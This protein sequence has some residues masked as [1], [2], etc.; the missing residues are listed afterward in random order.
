M[1]DL[2]YTSYD[3]FLFMNVLKSIGLKEMPPGLSSEEAEKRLKQYG[4]NEIIEEKKESAWKLLL[5]QFSSPI[6]LLLIFAAV[7]SGFTNYFQGGEY[8]DSILI[9]MIVF[10]AGIAGFVQDYK[11]EKT[12]EEL[13]KLAS[14]KAKVIRNGKIEV[15][16]S[17]EVVPGD[18]VLVEAGDVIPAD[19]VIIQGF[20][21]LDESMMT[22][23]SKAVKKK[24]KEEV[25]SG[26]NVYTGEAILK[27]TLTGMSTKMGELA[28]RMQEMK[29][30]STPFQEHMKRFTKK[31]V[32]FTLLIILI[33]FIAGFKKFGFLEALLIAVSLAVAA[34]PEGLPAVIT[35]AL[36][37]GAREMARA[38]ALVRR[39]AVTESIGSINIICT[40]K[41]GTLT[42]GKM[43]VVDEWFPGRNNENAFELFLEACY[44]CND[45]E[46]AI[47]NSEEEWVGDETDIALKKF[48]LRK[49]KEESLKGF[50]R[51]DSIPFDSKKKMMSVLV[52]SDEG[53]LVFSKG[54]P[55]VIVNKSSEIIYNGRITSLDKKKKQEVLR[56]NDELASKGYRV[57]ALA[58]KSTNKKPGKIFDKNLVFIGLVVLSDPLRKEVPQAVRE[59]HEAGIRVIMITGDNPKTALEIARQA[60][61]PSEEV[62]TGEEFEKMKDEELLKA[63]SKGVN[64][65]ART[66]P[67]HKLRLLK[68]LKKQGHIVAMTGDGVNDSLALKK[69]DVGIAMGV[70]GTEVAKEASDIILLDDNFSS[71]RNAVKQGRRIFDNIRK[72]VDYLLTCNT[73]EV[74]VV[75][76]ATLFLPFISLLPV[77]ILWINLITDGLPALAL[78]V[79]PARPDVMKRKPRKKT[80]SIINKKLAM[81]ITSIGI[82]KS[83]VILGTFLAVLPLGIDKARTVLFTGFIM[84]EFVRI[85]V[86]RFNEKL[87][88]PKYLFANKFLLLSL[89]GSLGLQLLILYSPLSYYF[90]VV[91]LGFFE[92]TVLLAGTFIGFVLGI[93]IAI[94]INQI[95]EEEY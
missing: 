1:A 32:I 42:L 94:I 33:T 58:F 37:L 2:F 47:K 23:E 16:S 36:S 4:R 52:K 84:Y 11:A 8:F 51:I 63:L 29:R 66:N 69:A 40:D 79:D 56:K 20:L 57:L 21:E 30:E 62:I 49:R 72:F 28:A 9:M 81:L 83:L 50:L 80:E 6:I 12:I 46:K 24:S 92:W 53:F 59:C 34:V 18:L 26:T 70:R 35:I 55:E 41:T 73:A 77:Q 86:I 71:I 17:T 19:G 64:V 38:K 45:A 44:Y 14:P 75:L 15:I 54:A 31:I 27:V 90:R 87:F 22:G 78:S 88:S 61:I 60:G 48:S 3:Y 89:A 13:K 95:T 5:E 68:L 65:F 91:P 7:L 67:F 43:E 10:A 74:M 82:K 25:F 93:A 76:T 39:L 85:A